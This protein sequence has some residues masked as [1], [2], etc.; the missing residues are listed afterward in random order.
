[1][2]G[3]EIGRGAVA[4]LEVGFARAELDWYGAGLAWAELSLSRTGAVLR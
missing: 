2:A 4:K 3:L 1:M